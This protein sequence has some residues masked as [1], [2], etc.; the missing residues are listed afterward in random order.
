MGKRRLSRV[1]VRFLSKELDNALSAGVVS[2]VYHLQTAEVLLLKINTKLGNQLLLIEPGFRVHITNLDY[3]IPKSPSALAKSWRKILRGSR[4]LAVKQYGFDRILV[5]ELCSR[6]KRLSLIVE[7]ID[8]GVATIVDEEAKVLSSTKYKTMRDRSI[9]KGQRYFFPPSRFINP[10]DTS[11]ELISKELRSPGDIEKIISSKL[12][13]GNIAR[14]ILLDSGVTLEGPPGQLSDDDVKRI[15]SSMRSVLSPDFNLEPSVVRC[16]GETDFF[17][18]PPKEL[19][20]C[21]I[22]HTKS[23]SE[24]IDMLHQELVSPVKEIRGKV[25]NK[26]VKLERLKSELD[27]AASRNKKHADLILSRL[28]DVEQAIELGKRGG[29]FTS[30]DGLVRLKE[31]RW[32]SRTALVSIEGEDVELDLGE[33]VAVNATSKYE[34]AKKLNRRLEEVSNELERLRKVPSKK[35]EF[36]SLKRKRK[37]EWFEKFRWAYLSSGKLIIGGKD[38]ITN[39]VLLKR[40]TQPDSVVLH[41]DMPGAPFFTII[42]EVQPSDEEIREAAQLTASYTTRAWN[43]NFSSLDVFWVYRKQL[44]KSPPSGEFLEKGAFVVRG[45]KNYIRGVPLSIALGFVKVDGEVKVIVSTPNSISKLSDYHALIAP[46]VTKNT[47]TAEEIA[48]RL[49]RAMSLRIEPW[50]LEEIK[51]RLPGSRSSLKET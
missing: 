34:L 3:P 15:I 26:I 27:S 12:G 50:L 40:H 44:S 23:I 22:S 38:H 28:Y 18:K 8:G 10:F 14:Q 20:G 33:K 11:D 31:I 2:N 49:S 32:S 6:G 5:M 39:E 24:A 30:N 45:M 19:S 43:S 36:I 16:D 37:K 7:L 25:T 29:S 21:H 48:R 42:S 35:E 47:K 9:V 41:S 1:E 13:M 46:G 4:I 51:S 17:I